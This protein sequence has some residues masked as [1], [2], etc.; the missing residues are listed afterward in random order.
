MKRKGTLSDKENSLIALVESSVKRHWD[1]MAYTDYGTDTNYTYG[2]V[3]RDIA[4]LHMMY[5]SLGIQKG[6]KIALC[7]KNSTHWAVAFLSIVTYGAVAVPILSDFSVEQTQN[8]VAHSDAKLLIAS[9][10]A[11]GFPL[12]LN[13]KTWTFF[14]E[15]GQYEALYAAMSKVSVD[16]DMLTYR[17][18]EPEEL[19]VISYTS[20]STGRSKG[21]MLPYRSLLSNTMFADEVIGIGCKSKTM[22]ILPMAHMYSFAFDFIYEF[23]TGC[24]VHFLTKIPSPH[25][26][27]KAFNDIKPVIVISVPLI[28]E[29]IVTGRIF[30]ILRKPMLST[31][32]K[33]PLVKQLV[34]KRVCHILTKAFGGNFYECIIGGAAFNKEVE[35]FLNKIGFRYTVG[36]G[37]TECGPI[38]AY[39]DWKKFVK[40]SCG[41]PAPRMEIKILSDDPAHV[42][43]EILARGANVMLGYFKNEEETARAIDKDGWL[44]TG[45]LG[46]MDK[47]GNIFING[48]KK[49]MIL[50]ANGQNIYPEEIEDTINTFGYF[51]ECIVVQR[52]DKLVALAAISDKTLKDKGMTM[53]ELKDQLSAYRNEM[54]KRL[55]KF[56][57]IIDIEI[58][59][60]GFEK[61]PKQS[62]KRYLYK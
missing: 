7:D 12:T 58:V 42:P 60:G 11:Y 35:D 20:G 10:D 18:D 8:I 41:K 40:F 24:H 4:A 55:P 59:E 54:N 48:R 32:V 57:N 13:T 26:V 37:M 17:R 49:N 47:D 5:E 31:L 30:P 36:Y 34:Y 46:T 45:D 25:V 15:D 2:D 62:I 3:A 29:K 28:I 19:A 23:C 9:K 53:D 50:S 16:K 14:G 21:V 6:D 51:D 44:H 43:G 39:E 52:E 22:A 33:I 38:L 1:F 56:A 61:T 27:I